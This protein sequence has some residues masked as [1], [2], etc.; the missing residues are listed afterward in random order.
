MQENRPGFRCF[1][2]LY[3][4]AHKSLAAIPHV[5]SMT[6]ATQIPRFRG[7]NEGRDILWPPSLV[8]FVNPIVRRWAVVVALKVP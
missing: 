2:F 5:R 1:P 8:N 7:L 3:T 4:P 6:D